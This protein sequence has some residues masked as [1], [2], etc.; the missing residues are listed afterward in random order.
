MEDQAFREW[1]IVELMGRSCI[2]GIVSEQT[3]GGETFIRVDVPDAGERKGYT[4][5][6]G[7]GAIYAMT[8][9]DEATCRLFVKNTY[10][11]PIN[12]FYLRMPTEPQE[13]LIGAADDRE[14][15]ELPFEGED[16]GGE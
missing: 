16:G 7:K 9:T 13:K 12:L 1:C 5:Y 14:G 6:F 2:G 8:P 15:D 10:Q 4:K 11:P 3:I